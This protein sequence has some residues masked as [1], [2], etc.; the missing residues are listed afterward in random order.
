M[1]RG[2]GAPRPP[3][4]KLSLPAAASGDLSQIGIDGHGNVS[5]CGY[6]VV[7]GDKLR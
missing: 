5:T 4:A 1:N 6:A 7:F 3:V 2:D